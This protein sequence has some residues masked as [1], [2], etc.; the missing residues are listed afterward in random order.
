[1]SASCPRQV[2]AAGLL[3]A[4]VALA[5]CADP[6][7]GGLVVGLYGSLTGPEAAYGQSAREGVELAL[8]ELRAGR[9]GR[10]GGLDVRLL[11]E[12]DRGDSAE[13]VTAVR[14]LVH[15][16]R[17]A[18]VIGE[19]ASP[20][21]LAAAP[22]CQQARVPMISPASTHPRVTQAGD[23]V[24][25][26]CFVD[27]FQ[28][29][30][31]ARFA[32]EHQRLRRVAMLVDRDN[33]YSAGLADDFMAA[34]ERLGGAVVHVRTYRAG[35]PDFRA[36]LA[37]LARHAPQALYVPGYYAEVG[38][39]ARQA[40]ALGLAVPLLGGDGWE[41]DRLFEVGGAALE[42]CY[43][44]SHFAADNPDST[45]QAFLEAYRARFGRPADAVAGLAYDAASVL[46][47]ALGRLADEDRAALRALSPARADSPQRERATRRLRDLLAATRNFPGVTGN[48][49]LDARRD[50]VKPAVVVGIRDGA[51][52]YVTTINP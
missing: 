49:T 40:R 29:A 37:D 48:I 38:R 23:F 10:I 14:R 1:M 8:A 34:F 52:R 33:D 39:I 4:L 15:E 35:D 16:R 32:V 5:G 43:H 13:A 19:M 12:D 45:Q 9:G 27:P 11:V 17:A 51:R 47:A 18:A 44:T 22:V 41:S 24:F 26:V 28:G 20:R 21:S 46:F 7:A 2:A 50:A 42:G 31:M 36:Q 6:H 25:R 3:A 30:A